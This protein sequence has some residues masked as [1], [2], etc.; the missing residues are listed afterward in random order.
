MTDLL[1]LAER[2]EALEGPCRETDV[3][4]LSALGTHVLEKQAGDRKPWWYIKG[5]DRRAYGSDSGLNS[6]PP[7]VPRYTTSLDAAKTLY[8]VLPDTI[9][10]CPRKATAAALRARAAMDTQP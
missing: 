9:P 3:A 7:P 1:K 2:V 4:V 10:S 8:P 6:Y 5:T